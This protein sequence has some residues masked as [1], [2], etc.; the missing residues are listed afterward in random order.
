VGVDIIS[1]DSGAPDGDRALAVVNGLRERQVLISATG[2]KG[3]VLK[4]RPPLPFA[5]QHVDRFV[6]ALVG[7]LDELG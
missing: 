7:V 3:N 5:T 2:S 6:E 1:S 4:I